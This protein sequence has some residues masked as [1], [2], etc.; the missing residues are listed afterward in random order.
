M[1]ELNQLLDD[2]QRLVMRM[3]Q[4]GGCNIHVYICICICISYI[5]DIYILNVIL[6]MYLCM[7]MYVCISMYVCVGQGYYVVYH[8]ANRSRLIRW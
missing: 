6:S 2:S 3:L 8:R 7:C 1:A 4:V 5:V